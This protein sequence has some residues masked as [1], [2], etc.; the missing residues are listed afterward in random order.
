MS[1]SLALNPMQRCTDSSFS[2]LYHFST[3]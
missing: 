1:L 2:V 3:F